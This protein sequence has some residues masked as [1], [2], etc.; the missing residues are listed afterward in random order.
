MLILRRIR[1][2]IGDLFLYM[3]FFWLIKYFYKEKMINFCFSQFQFWLL[4][5][6]VFV[7]WCLCPILW[8]GF[9]S[10]GAFVTWGLC[11]MGF[12]SWGLCPWGFSPMGFM[13]EHHFFDHLWIL[14]FDFIFNILFLI[15][16]KEWDM[17]F[18][19]SR[20]VVKTYSNN[21]HKL[22]Y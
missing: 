18:I 2:I 13:S 11:L 15:Y 17:K 21:R 22:V 5:L 4:S 12:L 6:G 19:L 3:E 8:L 1:Y 20:A 7:L 14:N 16:E 10:H 9:L